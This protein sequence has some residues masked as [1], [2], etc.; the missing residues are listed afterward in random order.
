[1]AVSK[2][3][4]IIHNTVDRILDIIGAGF[5]CTLPQTVYDKIGMVA[6]DFGHVRPIVAPLF[7]PKRS[8]RASEAGRSTN[9]MGRISTGEAGRGLSEMGHKASAATAP[10]VTNT[11]ALHLNKLSASTAVA[12]KALLMQ[13]LATIPE[14][15]QT[16]VAELVFGIVS[17][18]KALVQLNADLY[19]QLTVPYGWLLPPLTQC[20]DQYAQTCT[21]LFFSPLAASTTTN[22]VDSSSGKS[23]AEFCR[24]NSQKE[25]VK[26]NG[27]FLVALK[28]PRVSELVQWLIQ[29]LRDNVGPEPA[30]QL[31]AEEAVTLILSF[32]PLTAEVKAVLAEISRLPLKTHLS[33][34]A[35]FS[36][37]NAA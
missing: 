17:G 31:I 3:G 20:L 33:N 25:R 10:P 37:M 21:E 4:P 32:K 1:M 9:E 24:M 27:A 22:A 23:Y 8:A 18:N 36:L 30:K 2:A 19:Q 14:D 12:V 26:A 28:H 6:R 13:E 35:K 15:K 5:V 16:Q 29:T 7:P 34:K 11:V